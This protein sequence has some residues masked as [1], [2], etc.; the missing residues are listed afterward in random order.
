MA[1][2]YA[3]RIPNN[4]NLSDNRRLQRALEDWQPKFL[5]WWQDMGPAG[6]Q[7]REAYLRTAISVDAQ[8]WANFGYVK[9]PDYRW[10]IFL[11]EP[12]AGRKVNFGDHKGDD[13]WQEVPGEYRG[14]L[15]RL[16]VTQ[17]DTEPASVE[18][19]R[20]LGQTCPSLYDL[21]NLFQ[22]NVEEGRHLWAMVYLL[23]AYFGRDGREE[24][25]ALL[26][27]RSG[28]ADKPRILGAFNEATPDWLSFFMFTFFTDRDGKFQLASL[29]E[30]GFDPLSRT[31]RFMLTEEAHHMFVGETGISRVLQRTCE[32]MRDFKTDDVRKHGVIDLPT[33]QKYLNF[34][35][36]VSLDLFG[37]EI[38]T[39]AANYY[40]M[41]IKGRFDETRIADDHKLTDA[42]YKVLEVHGDGFREKE[43]S[44]LTALNERLRDDYVADC[45]RGVM[46]WNQVIKRA[47]IDFE[48]KLPHRAFH[49]QIGQFAELRVDPQGHIISQ[50]EWDARHH[51]WLPTEE[52]RLYVISLMHAVTEIGKYANW[53][54]PP[55]RGINNM[56]VDF[57][58]VRA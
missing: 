37:S 45:A 7:A 46:R 51:R 49:R 39:N 28:D 32:V 21:R 16:I 52:D 27:R 44:A 22:I 6:F 12:E 40:T 9:M 2:D 53:I 25:E 56:P 41:G 1:I 36:S 50:A 5:D 20:L 18:Q 48:L 55:A 35:F 42:A 11:A 19:Q 23:D 31:C 38:S 14:V 29:A 13:A 54:A 15:R 3:S 17:G 58:Y 26:Q 43:E 10:G 4:V 33:I 8:G 30:S 24:A 57:E 47:G 34:H